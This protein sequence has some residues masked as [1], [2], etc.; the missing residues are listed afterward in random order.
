MSTPHKAKNT[1]YNRPRLSGFMIAVILLP[2]IFSVTLIYQTQNFIPLLVYTLMGG[3]T[4]LLYRLDKN[5]ATRGQWRISEFT[6]HCCEFFGGW[7]GA[8]L[9]QHWL[10]HK[11]QK[12]SFQLVFWLIVSSH[13]LC[14]FDFM[15][16]NHYLEKQLLGL[17]NY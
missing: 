4:F 3:V 17:F 13:L 14:W 11:N 6:L 10:R 5:R 8:L 1:Q 15:A 2:F 7:A 16:F 9:A 12:L